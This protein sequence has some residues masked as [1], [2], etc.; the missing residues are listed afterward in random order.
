[1]KNLLPAQIAAAAAAIIAAVL[2]IPIPEWQ[3]ILTRILKKSTRLILAAIFAAITAA[4]C[5]YLYISSGVTISAGE[6]SGAYPVLHAVPTSIP[7][8]EP[9]PTPTPDINAPQDYV[10]NTSRMKF[11]YPDCASV[12]DMAEHNK[13]FVT[14]PRQAL[15]DEGYTPCG[16]CKP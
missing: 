14:Q 5:A 9:T 15:I 12:S 7:T 6:N 10:L 8:P 4:L 3:K 1:M 13:S 16:R 11:H 2:Y